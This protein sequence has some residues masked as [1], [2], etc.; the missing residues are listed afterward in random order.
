MNLNLVD[1][2]CD[3]SILMFCSRFN[4]DRWSNWIDAEEHRRIWQSVVIY[5]ARFRTLRCMCPILIR[6]R[7]FHHNRWLNWF[8]A[9]NHCY[10]WNISNS[11]VITSASCWVGTVMLVGGISLDA[12]WR[13][14]FI[15]R[16]SISYLV[17]VTKEHSTNLCLWIWIQ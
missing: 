6:F 14:R 10:I 2:R 9:E 15:I 3:Y 1:F 13:N 17:S 7:I 5:V 11:K 16:P 8:D 4:H 12:V